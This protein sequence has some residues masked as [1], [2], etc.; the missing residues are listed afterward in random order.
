MPKRNIKTH[1]ILKH[2]ADVA[3]INQEQ[4]KI[5]I[6][7]M[8]NITLNNILNEEGGGVIFQHFLKVESKIKK[9]RKRQNALNGVVIKPR[10]QSIRLRCV[11]MGNSRKKFEEYVEKLEEKNSRK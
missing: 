1:E 7:E 6:Q 3:G 4:V 8:A 10:P 11:L 2:I 5:V 9:P